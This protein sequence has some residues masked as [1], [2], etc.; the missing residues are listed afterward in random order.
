MRTSPT[1]SMTTQP[2]VTRASSAYLSDDAYTQKRT[3]KAPAPST[4]A[5]TLPFSAH[6]LARTAPSRSSPARQTMATVAT[7]GTGQAAGALISGKTSV[8]LMDRPSGNGPARPTD[9]YASEDAGHGADTPQAWPPSNQATRA[10]SSAGTSTAPPPVRSEVV[11][12]AP[13]AT[14]SRAAT[15]EV[16]VGP[17]SRAKRTNSAMSSGSAPPWPVVSAAGISMTS[18]AS[19]R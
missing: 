7:S 1:W 18:S 14:A 12:E 9:P 5:R 16:I 2:I 4:S 13:A 17:P 11:A 15:G 8:T 6:S 19:S 10:G 3:R